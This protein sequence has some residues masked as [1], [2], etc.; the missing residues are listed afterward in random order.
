MTCE[1]I[2]FLLLFQKNDVNEDVGHSRPVH[3]SALGMELVSSLKVFTMRY[4]ASVTNDLR[5]DW[6]GQGPQSR[7]PS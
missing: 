7:L 5:G 2:E 1:A 3:H 6:Q 4:L